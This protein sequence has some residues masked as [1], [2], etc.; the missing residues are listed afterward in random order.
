MKLTVGEWEG[1]KSKKIDEGSIR[2]RKK[3]KILKD[4]E[5]GGKVTE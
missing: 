5:E 3:E 2:K 1:M 4:R